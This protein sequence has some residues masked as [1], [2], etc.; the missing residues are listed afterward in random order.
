MSGCATTRFWWISYGLPMTGARMATTTAYDGKQLK[1]QSESN[2]CRDQLYQ[3]I[4]RLSDWL[5]KNDYRSY[6]PF[7]GLDARFLRPLAF[8]QKIL[9]T[10]LQQGVRRFP[11]N[12]RPLLGIVKSRST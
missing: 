3:S 11:L 5:E 9:R 8:N 1:F 12:V 4:C 10:V 7:D 6:D 2:A